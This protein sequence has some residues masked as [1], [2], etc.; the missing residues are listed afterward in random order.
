M[1][2]LQSLKQ[3]HDC[4]Y[5]RNTKNGTLLLLLHISIYICVVANAKIQNKQNKTENIPINDSTAFYQC[6][7]RR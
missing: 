2:K 5:I 3:Q 1:S 6:F 4:F 7:A